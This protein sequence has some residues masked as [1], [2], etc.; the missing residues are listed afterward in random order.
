LNIMESLFPRLLEVPGESRLPD[1]KMNIVQRT[2][3][4]RNLVRRTK[5][6]EFQANT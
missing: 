1:A 3:M 5:L 6:L 2:K 4:S